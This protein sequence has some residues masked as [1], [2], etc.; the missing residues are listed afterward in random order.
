M[1]G[2]CYGQNQYIDTVFYK[3]GKTVIC[4]IRSETETTL[5]YQTK[6]QGYYDEWNISKSKIS[7][8]IDN[9]PGDESKYNIVKFDDIPETKFIGTKKPVILLTLKDTVNFLMYENIDLKNQ[10]SRSAINFG[11]VSTAGNRIKNAGLFSLV[12]LGSGMISGLCLAFNQESRTPEYARNAGYIFA[13]IA[14][15]CTIAVP[16]ELLTAGKKLKNLK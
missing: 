5:I 6:D 7:K 2:M 1:A 11:C 4:K 8:Y 14:A 9:T 16:I 12:A 13:G 15:V 3:N 10:I